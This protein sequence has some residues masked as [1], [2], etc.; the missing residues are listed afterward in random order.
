MQ[1]CS[2]RIVVFYIKSQSYSVHVRILMLH[3]CYIHIYSNKD[4][5]STLQLWKEQPF[6]K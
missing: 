6:F 4:V 1:N 5:L 2:C 3:S